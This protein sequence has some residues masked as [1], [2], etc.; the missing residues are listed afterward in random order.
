MRMINAEP[1]NHK[2]DGAVSTG[3]GHHGKL[4]CSGIKTVIIEA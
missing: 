2:S 1:E 3:R 4:Y